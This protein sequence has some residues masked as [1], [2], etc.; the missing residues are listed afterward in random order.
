MLK[1]RMNW[2]KR[3]TKLYSETCPKC[4][5]GIRKKLA[6]VFVADP[7]TGLGFCGGT[8]RTADGSVSEPC[9]VFSDQFFQSSV[10]GTNSTAC[11]VLSKTDGT[12][13]V[14]GSCCGPILPSA[15][16]FAAVCGIAPVM[17]KP[18]GFTRLLL[19]NELPFVAQIA[20]SPNS[21]MGS[22]TDPSLSGR[23]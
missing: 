13:T 22:E 6:K 14:T 1:A 10:A 18:S 9:S 19:H 17:S 5:V 11:C 4:I 23:S 8:K 20:T 15:Q 7:E 3:F 12:E 21:N 2:A 16:S